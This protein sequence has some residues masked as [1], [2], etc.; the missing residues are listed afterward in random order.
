MHRTLR[1]GGYRPMSLYV[2]RSAFTL[3]EV[4]V[5]VTLIT[6]LVSI[7]IPSFQRAREQSK[8]L[9][10]KANS[11]QLGLMTAGYQAEHKDYVPVILNWHANAVLGTPP[12]ATWLSVALRRYDQKVSRLPQGYDPD[13]EG[14]WSAEIDPYTKQDKRTTYEINMMPDYFAC[15]FEREKLPKNAVKTGSIDDYDLWELY[16]RHESFHTWCWENILCD[17]EREGNTPEYSV[18]SWN[19]ICAGGSAPIPGCIEIHDGGKIDEYNYQRALNSPRKWTTSDAQRVR[20]GSLSEVSVV[21]CAQGE[22]ME[23]GYR[24][25]NRNSHRTSR[26]GGTNVIFADTHVEWVPGREVGWP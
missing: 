17:E 18:F 7:L 20:S 6:L 22:H 2:G 13:A 15:P 11:K 14:S 10:C 3:I 21:Y 1:E 26:Q 16:G 19:R 25:L 12:R 8:I 23:S 4:L 5:V 9:S 24:W